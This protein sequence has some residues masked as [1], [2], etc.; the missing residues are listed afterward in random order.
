MVALADEDIRRLLRQVSADVQA[1]LA[2]SRAALQAVANLSPALGEAAETALEQ[3]LDRARETSAAPRTVDEIE[4]ALACVQQVPGQ[5]EM[6]SA[7]AHA[8]EAAADA[9]PDVAGE[10]VAEARLS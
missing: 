9:L 6:M 3:E 8:L 10:P 2:L 1:S 4:A 7:L 5:V